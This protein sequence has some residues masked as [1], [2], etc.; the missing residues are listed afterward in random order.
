M[1]NHS[2]EL[3]LIANSIL[4]QNAEQGY[5]M[6]CYSKRDFFNAV[7][8]FQNAFGEKMFEMIKKDGTPLEDAVNMSESAGL[9]FRKYVRKYTSLDTTKIEEFL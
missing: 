2:A 7:I 9:E 5:P 4:K 1:K 3:E 6:P 8:I